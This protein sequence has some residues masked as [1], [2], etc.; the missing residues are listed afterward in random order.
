MR[1]GVRKYSSACE[2]NDNEGDLL[3]RTQ[4]TIHDRK[5]YPQKRNRVFCYLCHTAKK[6]KMLR[7]SVADNQILHATS[8][9]TGSRPE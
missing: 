8:N 9:P 6:N 5:P 7:T 4:E 2:V 1:T 3:Q